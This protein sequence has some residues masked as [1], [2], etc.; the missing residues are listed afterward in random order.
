L[1]R[2]NVS[3]YEPQW[4]QFNVKGGDIALIQPYK[5]GGIPS[6]TSS[7]LKYTKNKV[8]HGLGWGV[9]IHMEAPDF[10]K[11]SFKNLRQAFGGILPNFQAAAF[12]G[13]LL[14]EGSND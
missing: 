1:G 14:R 6:F 12:F 7:P 10:L 13:P 4:K 8:L 3:R 5:T 9:M 2:R 11:M